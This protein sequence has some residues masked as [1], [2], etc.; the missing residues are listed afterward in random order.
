MSFSKISE[1]PYAGGVVAN[2]IANILFGH[3]DHLALYGIS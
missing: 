1:A 3:S 2:N